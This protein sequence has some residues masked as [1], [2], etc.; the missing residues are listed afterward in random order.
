MASRF[1]IGEGVS[2]AKM[3]RAGALLRQ[4][5]SGLKLPSTIREPPVS[6]TL[7][8]HQVFGGSALKQVGSL[9]TYSTGVGM[10]SYVLDH[11]MP[12][13]KNFGPR[14]EH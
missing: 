2:C 11:G 6:A 8:L 12:M 13:G 14:L 4:P 9:K 3:P 5:G 7:S 10:G 1:I